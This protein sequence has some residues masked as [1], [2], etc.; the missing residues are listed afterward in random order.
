MWNAATNALGMP[1]PAIACNSL[2]RQR[3]TR[4]I[5]RLCVPLLYQTRSWTC[6]QIGAGHPERCVRASATQTAIADLP[7]AQ[8]WSQRRCHAV[9]VEPRV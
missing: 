6:A 5:Y 3:S 4:D 1:P 8:T 2:S 7:D 9:E